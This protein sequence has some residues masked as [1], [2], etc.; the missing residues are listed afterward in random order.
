MANIVNYATKFERQLKQKY[1]AGLTSAGLTTAD[2]R[3]RFLDAKTIK[4]PY[5]MVHGYKD[6]GRSGGFNRQDLENDYMIKTLEHDRDVEFFVDSM[7]VDETNQTLAAAN[8]TNVFEDE[9]AI[10]ETDCYRYSKLHAD[11]VSLGGT[12]DNTVI[13][14]ANTLQLFDQYMQEMDDAEVPQDGR[15]LYVIPAIYTA[16]KQAQQISR[17]IAVNTNN[18]NINRTVRSLDDVTL[19]RV[20]SGRMKTAYDFSDGFAPASDAQQINMM[21]VHPRSV[22]AVDKHAYIKFW[23]PGEHTAGDGWLYQN[24]KYGDLFLIDTR[25]AGVK[26][27]AQAASE[28]A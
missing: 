25:I 27:N 13:T 7:D 20:P 11:F 16:L 10:P 15:F 14:A 21:L 28:Q 18:G 24:R 19:V 8:V 17:S 2:Q 9:Q 26:I 12:V 4:I 23:A 22:I 5:I 1:Q 3:I 6:H